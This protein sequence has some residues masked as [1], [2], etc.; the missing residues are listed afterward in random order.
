MPSVHTYAYPQQQLT[1]ICAPSSQPVDSLAPELNR[2]LHALG[3]VLESS[4]RTERLE[5]QTVNRLVRRRA[6]V[7]HIL[8]CQHRLQWSVL[9]F[10]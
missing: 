9:T 3:L 2:S 1:C 8:V 10:P 6:H 4:S 7:L 5:R